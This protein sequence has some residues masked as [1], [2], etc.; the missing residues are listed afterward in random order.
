MLQVWRRYEGSM[1]EVW[2]KYGGSMEEVW[3]RHE[4]RH[5]IDSGQ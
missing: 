2:R 4:G 3:R 5:T 1:E